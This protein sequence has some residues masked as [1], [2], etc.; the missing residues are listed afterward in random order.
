MAS[1]MIYYFGKSRT[2]GAGDMK[3]LLGGKGANLAA[4]TKIGLPVPS[5]FT[6]TTEVCV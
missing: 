3:S 4:M 6:I 5:G 1:K 2:D